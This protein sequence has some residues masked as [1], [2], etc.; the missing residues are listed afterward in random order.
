VAEAV[1]RAASEEGVVRRHVAE[2]AAEHH[3]H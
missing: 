3:A 1:A 2:V